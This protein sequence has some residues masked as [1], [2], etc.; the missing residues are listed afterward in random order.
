VS[1]IASSNTESGE[2][3][4][5]VVAD[6]PPKFYVVSPRKFWLLFLLTGGVYCIAWFYQNWAHFKRATKDDDIWPGPRGLFNIFFAHSLGRMIEATIKRDGTDY[7]WD[8]STTATLY[9]ISML[10]GGLCDRLAW[11]DIGLP[12]T[13][14][15]AVV[16]IP[17]SGWLLFGFQ[18]AVNAACRDPRGESNNTMNWVNWVWMVIGSIWMAFVLYGTYL[19][20]V[21]AA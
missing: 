9:V 2:A 6:G 8:S 1:D 21:G 3:S 5:P 20:V 19:M 18:R 14:L 4:T 16:S 15:I 10:V 17:V 7:E 12:A 13:Q 11:R